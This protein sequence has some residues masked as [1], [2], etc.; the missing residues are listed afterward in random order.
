MS[1]S[2]DTKSDA[3]G[4][5]RSISERSTSLLQPAVL[6]SA[7]RRFARGVFSHLQGVLDGRVTRENFPSIVLSHCEYASGVLSGRLKAHEGYTIDG[8]WLPYGLA[9]YLRGEHGIKGEIDPFLD[10]DTDDEA[11]IRA[12]LLSLYF[13]IRDLGTVDGDDDVEKALEDILGGAVRLFLGLE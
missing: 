12:A 7:F 4:L 8:S 6:E 3:T 5:L 13:R 9:A 1:E 11:V 10:G 2:L